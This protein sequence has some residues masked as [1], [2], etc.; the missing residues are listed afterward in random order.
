MQRWRTATIGDVCEVVNGG[1]PKTGVTEYWHGTHNWITPAEMGNRAS[2]YISESIRKLSD[3][4]LKNSSAQQVPPNSLI[5]SS[6][7]PIGYAVVNT[8]PMAFNQGCKGLVPSDKLDTMFLFYYLTSIVRVL[9]DLGTGATFNELSA[10]KL[11]TVPLPLPPISE[12]RS[13]V[14][15]I[16][17]AFAGINDA[18]AHAEKNLANARE[19]YSGY[20]TSIFATSDQSWVCLTV[21]ELV[22]RN[23]IARPLDGNHGDIH[24]KQADFTECGVPFIMASDLI[25]GAVDQA[26]CRFISSRQ[27]NTLRKGFAKDGDV[28]LSHKGTIG[29]AAVLKTTH[30][31]VVLTPQV[32][33]YR[34][35]DHAVLA[36]RYMYH[37]FQSASFQEEISRIAGGGSTRAYI[38]IT[39]Q[40]KLH[41][42]FPPVEEQRVIA[43]ALDTL[44]DKVSRLQQIY[45]QKLQTLAELKQSI[46]QKA[47]AGE[48]T[49]KAAEREMAGV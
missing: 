8:V 17:E 31:H 2:P 1:T 25:D 14:A 45:A 28:L 6:R 36:T 37:F 22:L 46:L 18:I 19:L 21:E 49:A 44:A 12:Q 35:L 42:S 34:I 47:F 33:Y 15:V 39:S 16:D 5:L 9:D 24:P 27:A 32:T 11:R 7:A 4:G 10:G 29:R 48:L 41:I 26:N 30:E 38:G 23:I 43:A 40:L 3:A 13:I 20:T